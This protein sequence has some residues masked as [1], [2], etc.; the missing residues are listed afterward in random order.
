MLQRAW[1][2]ESADQQKRYIGK[3]GENFIRAE[4]VF[5]LSAQPWNKKCT[6]ELR[7]SRNPREDQGLRASRCFARVPFYK[8]ELKT[9][10]AP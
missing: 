10:R 5:G 9:M 7:A 4:M 2:P 1:S 3:S 6:E 8:S